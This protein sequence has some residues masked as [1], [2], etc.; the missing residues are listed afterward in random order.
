MKKAK[1]SDLR[2]H[3]QAKESKCSHGRHNSHNTQAMISTQTSA[4]LTS[5]PASRPPPYR[6][7]DASSDTVV[8][9]PSKALIG[10]RV[11]LERDQVAIDEPRNKGSDLLIQRD[12][13]H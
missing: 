10:R 1:D 5:I 6:H 2:H 8:R 9:P 11:R 4:G 13:R 12:R 3:P 7:A